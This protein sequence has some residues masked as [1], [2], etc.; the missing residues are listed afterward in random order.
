MRTEMATGAFTKG[1]ETV[2]K[3]GKE[4][5]LEFFKVYV[6]GTLFILLGVGVAVLGMYFATGSAWAIIAIAIAVA[7]A[8][9]LI[10]TGIMTVPMNIVDEKL[11]RAPVLG[12]IGNT[13]RNLLPAIVFY[14][15]MMAIIIVFGY[16][17]LFVAMEMSG[18]A[19][20]AGYIWYYA[21]VFLFSFLIQFGIY[22]LVVARSGV[23]GSF[24]KSFDIVKKSFWETLIYY[25]GMFGVSF[26]AAIVL[27]IVAAVL[28][29]IPAIL[30][31]VVAGAAN[32][33]ALNIFLVIIGALYAAALYIAYLAGMQAVVL[34]IQYHYWKAA[35]EAR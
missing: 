15:I 10:A 7:L 22:E 27:M 2:S 19:L 34:P 16:V 6:V 29:L 1:I 14:I 18:A 3:M 11:S 32:S 33:Q 21:F 23:L 24:G 28:F 12:I 26:A 20:I 9:M 30:G 4:L 17:P 31:I 5:F 13:K 35:R 25:I 8:V